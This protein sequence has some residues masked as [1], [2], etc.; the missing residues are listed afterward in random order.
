VGA[1]AVAVVL[2]YA[3][4]PAWADEPKKSNKLS[5]QEL[6]QEVVALQNLHDLDLS[7][8]QL[9][10]LRTIA[11]ETA[12][13]APP[14][15]QVKVSEQFRK[16][17]TELREALIDASDDERIAELTGRLDELREA[18]KPEFPDDGEI[19]E[20]AQQRAPEVLRLLTAKQAAAYI[21]AVA[22]EIKDP[23]EL[24]LEALDQVR[25]MKNHKKVKEYRD[26]VAEE[27]GRLVG[28][29]D[30][31]KAGKIND[32][33]VQWLIVV[34]SLKEDE[35]KTQ[36]PDLEKRARDIVGTVGPTEVI[37]NFLEH[38]LADVLSNPR[39]VAAINA[40]LK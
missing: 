8:T 27:V 37:R 15:G 16:T 25:Q 12:A 3:A 10:R 38:S 22:E 19:T 29:L 6:N 26:Q 13:K 21:G 2:S 20:E 28:G 7:P 11:K 18:E 1:G 32:Q 39:L 36:R 14:G 17:L 9:E 34:R 5:V 4:P 23:L 33:V 35:F 40:R 24:L 30:S 31:E